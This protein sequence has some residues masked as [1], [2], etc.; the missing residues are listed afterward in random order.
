MIFSQRQPVRAPTS[1]GLDRRSTRRHR[2]L[3]PR[4]LGYK[5]ASDLVPRAREN[6]MPSL[7]DWNVPAS[8]QPKPEDYG[9]DLEQAFNAVVGLRAIIPGDAYT[10]ETLGTERGGNGVFIRG[11]GLV[12][13]ICYLIPGDATN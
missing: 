5:E 8:A 7:S 3:R 13:T 1:K 9:Y 12:L 10:A 6:Q 11:N 2:M 4:F